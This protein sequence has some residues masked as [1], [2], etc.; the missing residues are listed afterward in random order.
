M[1]KLNTLIKGTNILVAL[2]ALVAMVAMG[3][4]SACMS[5]TGIHASKNGRDLSPDAQ[6]Y[7][8]YLSAGYANNLGD[9]SA[10]SAYFSRAFARRPEDVGLGRKALAAAINTGDSALA[11]TLSIEVLALDATDGSARAVLG[12]HALR[13]GNYKKAIDYLENAN[14]G[15]GFEDYNA[16]MRGWAQMGLGDKDAALVSF[17]SLEGGKYFELLGV[18]QRAIRLDASRRF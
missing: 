15:I 18:L 10:R 1:V 6:L 13:N 17:E 9:S 8:D 3:S 11:R 16:L 12:A 2:I 7:A 14:A 4:L 5:T